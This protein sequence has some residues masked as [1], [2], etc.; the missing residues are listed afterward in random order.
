[1]TEPWITKLDDGTIDVEFDLDIHGFDAIVNIAF[2]TG[3]VSWCYFKEG[4]DGPQ[5]K[6]W[7]EGETDTSTLKSAK[8]SPL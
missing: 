3:R 5:F 2:E 8:E 1:M 7:L 6:G 4:A